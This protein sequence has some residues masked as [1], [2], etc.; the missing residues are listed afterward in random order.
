MANRRRLSADE[1][2]GPN[3][4]RKSPALWQ[5]AGH[6]ADGLGIKPVEE[7][8]QPGKNDDAVL[9]G[10]NVARVDER[11]RVENVLSHTR[12]SR[13]NG[14]DPNYCYLCFE[15]EAGPLALV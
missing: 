10:P 11:R 15:Y 9:H 5:S 14:F 6:I 1:K 13:A 3:T 2:I 4:S 8:H 12:L 7:H